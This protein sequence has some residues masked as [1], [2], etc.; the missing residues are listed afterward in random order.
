MSSNWISIRTIAINA[1]LGL[2]DQRQMITRVIS[3]GIKPAAISIKV[4]WYMRRGILPELVQAG[5]VNNITH[6]KNCHAGT[7]ITRPGI[8][9]S[10]SSTFR[11]ID[12]GFPVSPRALPENW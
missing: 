8:N 2:S 1:F 4:I 5:T 12:A 10:L 11:T 9:D 3:T 6:V 7:G